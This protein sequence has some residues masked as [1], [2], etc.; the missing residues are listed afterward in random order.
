MQMLKVIEGLL[1]T[2]MAIQVCKAKE[3][4]ARVF[5]AHRPMQTAEAEDEAQDMETQLV[6]VEVETEVLAQ[7]ERMVKRLAEAEVLR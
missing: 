7:K 3:L 4:M 2:I 6:E 5:R 1:Q